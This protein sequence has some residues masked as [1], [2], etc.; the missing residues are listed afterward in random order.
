MNAAEKK[1]ETVIVPQA[2]TEKVNKYWDDHCEIVLFVGGRFHSATKT[3][4]WTFKK[5]LEEGGVLPEY[6]YGDVVLDYLAA[7][8]FHSGKQVEVTLG[9]LKYMITKIK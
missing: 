9:K 4:T 2:A 6:K 1:A 7:K 8:G 3:T 5:Q